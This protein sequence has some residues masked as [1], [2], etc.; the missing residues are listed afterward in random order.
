VTSVLIITRRA[1]A[2]HHNVN[3]A[4]YHHRSAPG[5]QFWWPEL[6][7]EV[8]TGKHFD[9]VVKDRSVPLTGQQIG[10][11]WAHLRGA[12]TVYVEASELGGSVLLDTFGMVS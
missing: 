6:P 5:I 11:L 10:W 4:T 7:L 9:L 12:D 2:L 1:E 3:R 8:L